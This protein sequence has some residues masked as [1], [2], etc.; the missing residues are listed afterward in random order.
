MARSAIQP[1]LPCTGS[2]C[3]VAAAPAAAELRE[4]LKVATDNLERTFQTA[5]ELSEDSVAA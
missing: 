5:P 1:A 4:L 2:I 3:A